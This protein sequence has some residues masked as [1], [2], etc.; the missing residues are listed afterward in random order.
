M[1]HSHLCVGG[2]VWYPLNMT[3]KAAT[4]LFLLSVLAGSPPARAELPIGGSAAFGQAAAVESQGQSARSS[5]RIEDSAAL[6][7]QTVDNGRADGAVVEGRDSSGRPRLAPAAEGEKKVKTD[8]VPAPGKKSGSGWTK[9]DTAKVVGGGV[10][11]GLIGFADDG[12]M[13]GIIWGA[14]GLGAAYLMVKGDYGGALGTAIGS[15]AG[16]LLGG[17]IGSII[18]GLVGGI[19]GHFLG[20][21]LGFNK[22]KE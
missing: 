7:G 15:I 3:A 1:P 13:G 6:A 22:K 19:I 4:V 5:G 2:G 11:S 20:E 16:S 10:L 14:I 8:A 18:G 9:G 17:P 21:S 12:M